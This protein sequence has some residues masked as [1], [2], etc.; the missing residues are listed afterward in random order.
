[1]YQSVG[2]PDLHGIHTALVLLQATLYSLR[3]VLEIAL[4]RLI[5]VIGLV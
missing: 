2:P 5:N 3:V 1:M 4:C